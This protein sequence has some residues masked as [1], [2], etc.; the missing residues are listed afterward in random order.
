M[1]APLRQ[2]QHWITPVL[3]VCGW[4]GSGK[5]TL[6]ERVIPSIT[7]DGLAVA[8]VKHDAHDVEV[9]RPGK[10]SDRLYRAGASVV[11]RSPQETF[12]RR[13]SG[14]E[15]DLSQVLRSL[16]EDHDLILVEGHKGTPLPK[17]WLEARNDTAVADTVENLL[18]KLPWH[19]D[20]PQA[21]RTLVDE[22]VTE[23]HRRR[24][25]FAGALLGGTS[26]R[27]GRPKQLLELG[28]KTFLER[29]V[30]AVSGHAE[31]V[32][33]LGAGEVPH[34]CSELVRLPD[35][36]GLGGPLAGL[37][38]AQRWAPTAAWVVV[39]CDLPLLDGKA[40]EWL[41]DQRAPGRWAVLPRDE[42]GR[43]EPLAAVYE[44]QARPL[45]ER[46]ATT[47]L[48]APRK[49][50]ENAKVFSPEAPR[51]VRDALRNVNTGAELRA[52]GVAG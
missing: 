5:T 41:L 32:V 1:S 14:P 51:A 44:P 26:S 6:L 12:S 47:D 20:R 4:S 25:L 10:D 30:R 39:A 15:T 45:L 7:A 35:P 27:M 29:V 23:H 33:L 48:A 3:A 28:G 40:V 11:L 22:V 17:L 16:A 42:E 19:G 46:L 38:S 49:I 36:P 9:D 52:L 24:R 37:L 43:L 21:L 2:A 34:A 18:G 31:G 50:A 13:L 8:V